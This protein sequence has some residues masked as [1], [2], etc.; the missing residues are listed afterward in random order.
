MIISASYKTDIPTFYGE[1]FM[2]RLRVGY[3]KMVNPYGQQIY[4]VDLAPESVDGFVFW[5]K[6]IGPFLKYLPEI[7]ERGYPFIVQ[8]SINGYP[9]ELE[10]RVIDYAHTIEHMKR[11]AGEFGPDVAVWRYDPIVISSLTPL[12]WHRE[13]FEGLTK[14]LAGATG[15]VVVSFAQVYKKTRRNMDW[16]AREF[17]FDWSEHEKTSDEEVRNLV[18][19]FAHIARAYGM[20]L[21]ICSQKKFLVPGITEEARCVDADRLERVAH[22]PITDKVKQKGNRKECGCFASKDI[23]EYDTCPHGCVYCYAV[24][25]RDLALRRFKEHDPHGEFLFP[26]KDYVPARDDEMQAS[27]V[28]PAATVRKSGTGDRQVQQ[29]KLF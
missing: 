11:L 20:Q 29:E 3:C 21:R 9:R 6:N 17:G 19:D 23:G 28:I 8:H 18:S 25:N 7:Q 13:N 5:T 26:A 10:D 27:S 1:W 24:Q 15:E 4:R 14:R 2:N 22:R 16:A 12:D